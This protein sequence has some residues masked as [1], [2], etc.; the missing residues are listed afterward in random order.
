MEHIS[1][2]LSSLTD[3]MTGLRLSPSPKPTQLHDDFL[4]EAQLLVMFD[5]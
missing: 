5:G 1:I 3:L 4:T 2:T